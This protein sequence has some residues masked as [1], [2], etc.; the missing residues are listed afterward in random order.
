MKVLKEFDSQENVWYDM[1]SSLQFRILNL[2]SEW[3]TS[4]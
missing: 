3:G 4:F 2:S 1:T